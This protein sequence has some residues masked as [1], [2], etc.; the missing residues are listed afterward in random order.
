MHAS[1]AVHVRG[2][3]PVF[4][5]M[6]ASCG[7]Q[8]HCA[9]FSPCKHCLLSLLR[10]SVISDIFQIEALAKHSGVCQCGWPGEAEEQERQ[11]RASACA[12]AGAA[13]GGWRSAQWRRGRACRAPVCG[14]ADSAAADAAPG[15]VVNTALWSF[16]FNCTL[17]LSFL[18]KFLFFKAYILHA[19]DVFSAF[20]FFYPS[21]F[22]HCNIIII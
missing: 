19:F 14:G 7:P 1:A 22:V 5:C 11:R 2:L 4:G 20:I 12:S 6:S 9:Q 15:A 16:T 3:K 8:W 21:S 18:C 17:F 10:S 13:K